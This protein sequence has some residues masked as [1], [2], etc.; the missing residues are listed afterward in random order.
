MLLLHEKFSESHFLGKSLIT[1]QIFYS[2]SDVR[3]RLRFSNEC[4]TNTSDQNFYILHLNHQICV[5]YI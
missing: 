3:T 5:I 4:D 2:V 1:S